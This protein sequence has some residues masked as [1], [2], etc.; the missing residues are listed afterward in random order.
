MNPIILV[1][2]VNCMQITQQSQSRLLRSIPDETFTEKIIPLMDLD[3]TKQLSETSH[4]LNQLAKVQM[5]RF[6]EESAA[7][8]YQEA[9]DVLN[10]DVHQFMTQFPYLAEGAN[11]YNVTTKMYLRGMLPP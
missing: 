4:H 10:L 9:M 6:K 11:K 1:L 2:T 3:T 7:A 5:D 8:Y